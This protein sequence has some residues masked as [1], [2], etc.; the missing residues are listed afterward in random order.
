MVVAADG[1]TIFRHRGF[2]YVAKAMQRD[3]L[4]DSLHSLVHEDPV[5]AWPDIREFID[6]SYE[7][8][9]YWPATL[10]ED[11]I[12]RPVELAARR[13]RTSRSRE[14]AVPIGTRRQS[15]DALRTS[16]RPETD[17]IMALIDEFEDEFYLRPS[18]RIC[19]RRPA[20]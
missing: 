6:A 19:C 11:L 15:L 14:Q 1:P 4:A 8:D 9:G 3:D 7:D 2:D 18:P 17:R 10:L 12:L 13:D 16:W 20:T 5:R